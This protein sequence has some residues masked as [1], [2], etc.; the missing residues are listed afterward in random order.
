MFNLYAVSLLSLPFT[1]QAFVPIDVSI[2]RLGD[3]S[4][5]K[6]KTLFAEEDKVA[7]A[8]IVPPVQPDANGDATFA[9]AESLGRGAAKVCKLL[10]NDSVI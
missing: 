2:N 3:H 7:E 4:V 5:F 1:L 10:G 8:A 6:S 9:K